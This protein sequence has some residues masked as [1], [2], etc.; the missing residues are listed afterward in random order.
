MEKF[1]LI[2]N[3]KSQCFEKIR[4]R[5]AS[6]PN[7]IILGEAHSLST[8]I[9]GMPKRTSFDYLLIE[10]PQ[11]INEENYSALKVLRKRQLH[12][13]IILFGPDCSVKTMLTLLN[14]GI[15]GYFLSENGDDYFFD[16]WTREENL[17]FSPSILKKLV[18]HHRPSMEDESQG[19]EKL[20]PRQLDILKL[21]AEGETY[22][23][24]GSIL[25][26]SMNGVKFHLKAIYQKFEV[27]NRIQ[28]VKY[29]ERNVLGQLS[30][31]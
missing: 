3:N 19:E 24:I 26:I 30:Q 20:T 5:L 4:K 28:A 14:A 9:H 16:M 29:Y 21:L 6:N 17:F 27:D 15:S 31:S 8:F 22:D 7:V 25:N 23:N 18:H 2:Y 10:A 12:T 11:K 13:E 1:G